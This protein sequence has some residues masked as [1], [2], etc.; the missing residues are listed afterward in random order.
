MD[1]P[2]LLG[3]GGALKRAMTSRAAEFFVLYGDSLLTCDLVAIERA[4]EA[5]GRACLMTVVRNDNQ[6]DRSNVVFTKGELVAYDK[7][8]SR[9]DMHHIDYGLGLIRASALDAYPPGEAFDLA[10]VY[11]DQLQAGQVTGYD[12][13]TRFYEIGSAEGLEDTRRFLASRR[14]HGAG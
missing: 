9:P 1:G 4:Y 10:R 6:W 7:R 2:V 14:A 8:T 11:Q 3:T 5:A 12:V 13:G